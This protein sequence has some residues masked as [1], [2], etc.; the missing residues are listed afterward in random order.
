MVMQFFTTAQIAGIL[1]LLSLLLIF[2]AVGLIAAQGR[3]GG[4]AAAFRGVGTQTKDAS[5]L[6][7]LARFAIPST[8][9]Q[10]AGFAVF[11]LLLYEAGDRGLAIAALALVIFSAALGAVEATFQANVT[12]WAAEE[13][14]RTG[15]VPELY[16]PLRRWANGDI[17]LAYMSTFLSAMVLLSWS[18]LRTELL[19]SWIGWVALVWS[20]LAF[21]IYFLVI[22]APLI[23]VG[24]IFLFGVGL[25]FLG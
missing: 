4:M 20:L 18:A 10:L 12:T 14:A 24:S 16:E 17:Q 9:A 8:I 7:T 15:T 1:L 22:G 2:F 21:P 13:S 25:L 5:G 11:T 19:L 3:L 23:M 6:R